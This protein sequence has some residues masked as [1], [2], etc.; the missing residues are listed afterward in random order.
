MTRKIL[1]IGTW[2]KQAR[3]VN[4]TVREARMRASF[5]NVLSLVLKHISVTID[6]IRRVVSP[7]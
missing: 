1:C 7:F 3:N 4:V 5:D 6:D 2:T